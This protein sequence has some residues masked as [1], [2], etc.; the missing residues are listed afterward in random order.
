MRRSAAG[1]DAS[2]SPNS[3]LPR[4]V[5]QGNSAYC[6]KITPRSGPGPV[7]G[8]PSTS[9]SPEVGTASPAARLSR[10]LLPHPDGPTTVTNSSSPMS[11]DTS[12]RAVKVVRFIGKVRET[13]RKEILAFIGS[14]AN[15]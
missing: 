2:F 8:F 9:T 5:S 10:V 13:F 4:T 7:T 11:S 3:T 15:G 6:W 1:T 14:P 12:S